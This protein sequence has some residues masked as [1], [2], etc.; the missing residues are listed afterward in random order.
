MTADSDETEKHE[1]DDHQGPFRR[2][3]GHSG[4]QAGPGSRAKS[5]S[6]T[7]AG[8]AEDTA[9]K[10][11]ESTLGRV[12]S[13]GEA[14]KRFATA[15]GEKSQQ[16]VA[17]VAGQVST[18]ATAAWTI[19]KYR[20]VIA[21]GAAAGAVSVVGGAYALGRRSAAAHHGPITRL[22]GGRISTPP[23]RPRRDPPQ[24]GR[25][26][27]TGAYAPLTRADARGGGPR[28]AAHRLKV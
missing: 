16:S 9:A 26:G 24:R 6:Q 18:K 23:P 28:P 20:K 4:R 5:G 13:A 15:G 25:G 1:R 2:R 3:Q 11:G 17:A 27:E 22:T 7:A 12:G 10:A 19:L 14:T 8:K 21:A